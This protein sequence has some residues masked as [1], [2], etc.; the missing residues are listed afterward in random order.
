MEVNK[1]LL[2]ANWREKVGDLDCWGEK[3]SRGAAAPRLLSKWARADQ[4]GGSTVNVKAWRT[5][6]VSLGPPAKAR[7]K[8]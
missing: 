4:M 2:G 5:R 7:V 6:S 3:K 8:W 1:K